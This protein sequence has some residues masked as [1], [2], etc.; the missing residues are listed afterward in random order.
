MKGNRAARAGSRSKQGKT[1]KFRAAAIALTR[2]ASRPQ[3]LKLWRINAGRITQRPRKP[4][5][6][7]ALLPAWRK[8]AAEAANS[9]PDPIKPTRP[10]SQAELYL[11]HK[12]RGTLDT[13]YGMF[14]HEAP[15]NKP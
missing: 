12:R 14:P 9:R 5:R 10:P 2:R 11:W 4:P 13:Y 15:E 3:T 1:R 8:A 7:E 6:P